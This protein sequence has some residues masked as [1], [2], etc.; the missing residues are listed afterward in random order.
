[1]YVCM[2][3]WWYYEEFRGIIDPILSN[4]VAMM[5]LS[6]VFKLAA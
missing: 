4:I 5:G 6:L 3:M 2:F 1:M